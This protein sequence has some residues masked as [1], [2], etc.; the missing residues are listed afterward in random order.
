MYVLHVIV[1]NFLLN[2]RKMDSPA[3]DQ[4]AILFLFSNKLDS[5]ND[6][7]N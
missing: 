4:G 6:I 2:K 7:Q 5:R 3:H 1:F